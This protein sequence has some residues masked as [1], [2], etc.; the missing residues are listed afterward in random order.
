[1]PLSSLLLNLVVLLAVIPI[2]VQLLWSL[3]LTYIQTQFLR[4]I[5]WVLLEVKPPKEVFKSPQAM[6]LVINTLYQAGGTGNWYAKYWKGGLRAFFSLEIVSLEG[7]IHFYIRTSNKFQKLI[8]SQIYAQY[9]QAEVLEVPDYVAKIPDFSKNAS[10]NLWGCLLDFT[11]DDPFPIKTYIDY[12][13]DKAIGSLDEAQRIDPITPTLEFMGSIGNGEHIMMQIIVRAATDRFEVKDKDGKVQKNKKWTDKAKA[14][15]KELNAMLNEKDAE[16]KVTVRRATKGESDVVSGIERKANK[17]GFDTG[18][19]LMYVAEKANFDP[20]RIAGL[21]GMVRQ[22]ST[23]DYNGFRPSAVT[24]FDFP[25]QDIFGKKLFE[26]KL[27]MLG[28]YKKRGY[29][30]SSFDFKSISTYFTYPSANSKKALILSTEE[31]A[32]LFHLPGKVAETPTFGR[33]EATK[34]EPPANLPI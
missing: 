32:T 9:P 6:E 25:W 1:M 28:G 10:I 31:L 21:T 7:D 5:K 24:D 8:E 18:I 3:W 26:K 12:G 33:I 2:L 20:N 13:L 15:I 17:I 30:Y 11:K 27:F 14:A 29:F 22:Y 16:G 34:A 4:N 19:R 23:N